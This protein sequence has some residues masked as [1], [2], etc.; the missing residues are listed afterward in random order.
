MRRAKLKKVGAETM[1]FMRGKYVLDEVGNDKDQ[2]AFR[3]GDQ[4]V[5]TIHIRKRSYDFQ[6]GAQAVRV[7]DMESLGEAKGLIQARMEPNRRP[8][9]RENAVY[10]KCGH[11]CDLCQ[12]YVGGSNSEEF[13]AML[14]EHVRRVYGGDPD[15]AILPCLGCDHG[16]LD[17]K[18]D[19]TQLKCAAKKGLST[20]QDC[21][22]YY[23]EGECSPGV[24]H[25]H[26]IEPRSRTADDVTWA[27]LPY[28]SDQYGN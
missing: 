19:C 26:D 12:H 22:K 6:V 15:E 23:P 8:F 14:I 18:A 25:A 20:C 11:R 10:A 1:R 24:S 27:I 21:H 5:L 7:T 28:V 9:P 16:G 2:L 3:D 13:R 17:G 4:T